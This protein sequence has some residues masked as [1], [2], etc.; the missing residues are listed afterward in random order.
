MK[1]I[2]LVL[3]LVLVT[4]LISCSRSLVRSDYDR[5]INFAN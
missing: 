3:G 2:K 1:N 4:G 5:E